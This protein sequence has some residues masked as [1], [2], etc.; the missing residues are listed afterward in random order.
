MRNHVHPGLSI[1]GL[2][3]TV[4]AAGCAERERLTGPPAGP[5]LDAETIGA[6]GGVLEAE[7][8]RLIV[9]PGAFALE[10]DLVLRDVTASAPAEAHR[11]TRVFEVAGVPETIALP[12]TLQ[13]ATPTAGPEDETRWIRL[14][15]TDTFISSAK[16]FGRCPVT[17]ATE[18]EGALVRALLPAIPA[19]G[20]GADGPGSATETTTGT[21]QFSA[22]SLRWSF[23]TPQGHFKLLY[24]LTITNP[25]A[26]Q[27]GAELERAYA[28]LR[29]DLGLSWSKRTR[30]ITVTIQDFEAA[31][32]EAWGLHVPSK[33]CGAEYDEIILNRQKILANPSGSDLKATVGHELFHLMQHLYDPR[34]RISQGKPNEWFWMN[35]A[36]STWFERKMIDRTHIPE[37]VREADYRFFLYHALQYTPSYTL[38]VSCNDC[39]IVQNHGYGASLFLGA[40]FEGANGGEQKIGDLLKRRLDRE[41]PLA[42]LGQVLAPSG[43]NL[44]AAWRAFCSTWLSGGVYPD[45]PQFPSP[46]KIVEGRNDAFTFN[47][48]D[49][50]L[51][52]F[53][54]QAANYAAR[55]YMVYFNPEAA[56]PL[57]APATVSYVDEEGGTELLFYGYKRDALWQ[58]LGTLTT[59]GQTYTVANVGEWARDGKGLAVMAVRA[60]GSISGYVPL[61]INVTIERCDPLAPVVLNGVTIP[62]TKVTRT[63]TGCVTK[64]DLSYSSLT[65]PNCLDGIDAHAG[66]LT[67]L[68]LY[69]NTL[70]TVDLSDLARCKMLKRLDLRY[71]GLQAI[72]LEPLGSCPR[73]ERLEL[74]GN[75]L[76]SL[77]LGPLATCAKLRELWLRDNQIAGLDLEPLAAGDSL[78]TLVL[79]NNYLTGLD[80]T[81]LASLPRLA[82]LEL[83]GCYLDVLNLGPLAGCPD[84][85]FLAAGEN[86]LHAV[87]LTPL[88]N[89]TKLEFISFNANQLS[90]INLTPLASCLALR[91]INLVNNNLTSIDLAPLANLTALRWLELEQNYLDSETC[92]QV[93]AYKASHPNCAV[94][95]DCGCAR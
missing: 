2:V 8:F 7:G 90:A 81:P 68:I 44:T 18:D 26:Q 5:D 55:L 86:S 71:S 40:T 85:Y 25:T 30:P 20:A 58:K 34:N 91:S 23:V 79:S 24:D 84:L 65:D 35:E 41:E 62:E 22:V 66:S 1:L 67:E 75:A 37:S 46:A 48:A 73:L 11:I 89:H 9:P 6:A 70:T 74:T 4:L 10:A 87:D 51:H 94:S 13:L 50:S 95:S 52:T 88:A 76:T 56:I 47:A 83:N 43:S 21:L 28:L 16:T 27:I 57:N 60:T 93:C 63:S 33:W 17:L 38:G 54:W 19:E 77:N 29:D 14:E 31:H 64:I 49:Q 3:L 12:C 80:L 92:Q 59:P 39:W 36:M 15:E 53:Q 45:V 72:S 32:A 61:A 69:R 82:T 42:A 78:R